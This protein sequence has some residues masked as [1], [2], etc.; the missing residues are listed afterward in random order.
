MEH[1]DHNEAVRATVM[2][3]LLERPTAVTVR[4]RLLYIYPPTLGKTMLLQAILQSIDINNALLAADP[5][6]E[7]LRLSSLHPQEVSRICAYSVLHGKQ[8]C[9]DYDRVEELC[10]FFGELDTEERAVFLGLVLNLDRTAEIMQYYG[11]DKELDTMRRVQRRK[12]D[13]GGTLVFCGLSP[14]GGVIDAACERYGWSVEYVV[15]ELSHTALQLLQADQVKTIYL[16]E[17]ERRKIHVP[18]RGELV[19]ADSMDAEEMKKALGIA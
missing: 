4:D 3:A 10:D 18:R 17:E 7:T 9:C 16:T 6:A 14:W 5:A 11:I 15:W 19:K 1:R 8:Q 12:G 13:D 2:E